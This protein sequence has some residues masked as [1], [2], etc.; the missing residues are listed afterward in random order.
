LVGEAY[1][2]GLMYGEIFDEKDEENL[3][4]IVLS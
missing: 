1:L 4:T 3:E 2:H